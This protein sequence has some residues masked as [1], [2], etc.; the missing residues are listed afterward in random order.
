MKYKYAWEKFYQ[1][2]LSLAGTTPQIQTRLINASNYLVRL[3]NEDLPEN[4]VF[5]FVKLMKELS[6]GIPKGNEGTIAAFCNKLSNDDAFHYVEK[7]IS[8][9]N[10][11][12]EEENRN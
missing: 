9:F 7:I 8:M 12:M 4:L 5:D 3:R 6:S 10:T 11:I 2:L 1:A